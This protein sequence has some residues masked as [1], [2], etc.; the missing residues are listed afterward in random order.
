MG[1]EFLFYPTGWLEVRGGGVL[2]LSPFFATLTKITNSFSLA[3]E[4][5]FF[6]RKKTL[7]PWREAS[8]S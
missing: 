3:L 8:L 2:F 1:L 4:F 6:A 7:F 5:P